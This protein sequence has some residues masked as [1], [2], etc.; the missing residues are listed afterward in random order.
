V[1]QLE[2]L[3]RDGYRRVGTPARGFRWVTKAGRVAS[4]AERTRLESL[5]LPPAWTDVHASA[6]PT[7]KLQ[8]IGRDKAGRWQYR[9]HPDF[10]R[11]QEAAKYRRLL[12]FSRTLPRMRA[13]VDRDLRLP[14]LP[15]EKVLACAVRVLMTCFVRAGSE[16]HMRA[17]GSFGIATLRPRHVTIEKDLVRFD[18]PA[19]SGKRQI[20]ELR[21]ARVA[22]VLRALKDVPGRDV[23][24]FEAD[25]G[26]VDV[27]RRHINAYIREVMG[28]PFTA[29]DF[30]TWAGTLIAACELARAKPE[31]IPERTSS[32]RVVTA[33]V[34]ATAHVLGNTPAVCR[35]SYINPGI[36]S[37]FERGEVVQRYFDTVEELV[38]QHR[39]LH[40]AEKA[41]V[42]LL[43]AA[44]APL[45]PRTEAKAPGARPARVRPAGDLPLSAAGGP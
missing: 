15:R 29:K 45:R 16:V 26:F 37:S 20:R 31:M 35:S 17:N 7:S 10:R 36:L 43:E 3:R 38:H 44:E 21:D 18:F 33:A 27:R 24:K 1:S 22:R 14:G 42:E 23:L 13:A 34:K 19:K 4:S 30:R 11:H 28:G 5:R 12:R 25:D 32:R 41:L 9:Y 40:R 2:K 8:A 39:G 6:A